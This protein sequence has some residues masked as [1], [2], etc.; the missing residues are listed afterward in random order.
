M[1]QKKCKQ[2][3]EL[4]TPTVITPFCSNLCEMTAKAMKNLKE[5][6]AKKKKAKKVFNENDKA[7]LLEKA[8]KIFNAF[9]RAR[10]KDKACISC[11]Y[12]SEGKH[13]RQWHAGHYRPA[14]Q[15]SALRFDETNVYKQCSMCNNYKSGNL[16][17]YRKN[18]IAKIGLEAVEKLESAKSLKTW[19]VEELKDIIKTYSQ[20]L[21]DLNND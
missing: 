11:G 13:S 18:L 12:I 9:I 14:G 5:I 15:N 6:K 16:V 7:K 10:D 8:Q 17:N 4:F 19:S 3:G 2:C 1:K 21:K 20:K